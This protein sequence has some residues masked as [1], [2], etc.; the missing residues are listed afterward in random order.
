MKSSLH[1]PLVGAE[2]T[3]GPFSSSSSS[4]KKSVAFADPV[5]TETR[6]R[7]R[8][9]RRDV[10]ALFYDRTDEARF[11]EEVRRERRRRSMGCAP[12]DDGGSESESDDEEEADVV[13]EI[14]ES[15]DSSCSSSDEDEDEDN[16]DGT[17]DDSSDSSSDEDD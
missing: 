3:F 5:V 4:D 12:D 15:D 10:R 2:L 9:A 14:T 1:P 13:V 17:F 16:A 11:R 7:P 6:I 8:T